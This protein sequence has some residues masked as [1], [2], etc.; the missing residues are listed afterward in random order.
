MRGNAQRDGR[1]LLQPS[2]CYWLVN[3]SG[4]NCGQRVGQ[5]SGP[6]LAICEPKY[7]KI[8][9]PVRECQQFSTPFSD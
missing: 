3:A 7:T 8:S 6:I 2:K 4:Q 1:P 9:L 5:N